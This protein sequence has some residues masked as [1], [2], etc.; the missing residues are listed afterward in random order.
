M[1][2][3]CSWKERS[4]ALEDEIKG[5]KRRVFESEEKAIKLKQLVDSQAR[6]VQTLRQKLENLMVTFNFLFRHCIATLIEGIMFAQNVVKEASIYADSTSSQGPLELHLRQV[7]RSTVDEF[8]AL[9]DFN[10]KIQAQLDELRCYC[11]AAS[12][13]GQVSEGEDARKARGRRYRETEERAR[14]LEKH[15]LSLV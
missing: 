14:K 13:N 9:S 6:D 11:G 3:K 8:T 12:N 7:Q 15:V 4:D 1:R 10:R 2:N 5:Y